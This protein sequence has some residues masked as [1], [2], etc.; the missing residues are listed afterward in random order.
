M[1]KD[2]TNDEERDRRDSILAKWVP[3]TRYL[4]TYDIPIKTIDGRVVGS[5]NA[6]RS[7]VQFSDA[8]N[9]N[10]QLSEESVF[11]RIRT[12]S[13]SRRRMS[14]FGTGTSMKFEERS[15]RGADF[16]DGDI[17]F[18]YAIRGGSKQSTSRS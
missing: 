18:S 17:E 3:G 13:G 12:L 15:I 11:N 2:G 7:S 5:D 14:E 4:F 6:F 10:L 9:R 16:D 1:E 8:V